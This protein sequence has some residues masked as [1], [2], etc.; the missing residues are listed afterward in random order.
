MLLGT[1]AFLEYVKMVSAEWDIRT[2]TL[3]YLG[4]KKAEKEM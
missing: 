2:R 4:Q 1:G 3:T